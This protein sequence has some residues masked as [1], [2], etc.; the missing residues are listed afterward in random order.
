MKKNILT[1]C[2]FFFGILFVSGQ[3][4]YKLFIA[5]KSDRPNTE[6]THYYILQL[7]NE[8]SSPATFSLNNK[9]FSC[10][11]RDHKQHTDFTFEFYNLNKIQLLGNI[12]AKKNSSVKFYLKKIAP[13]NA[14]KSSWNCS[15]IEATN[16]ENK[17]VI[18]I[19]MNSLVQDSSRVN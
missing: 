10:E 1:I 9:K 15:L 3:E 11:N 2:I 14:I 7:V 13:D 17:K 6:K 12:I 19:L 5:E 18:S 16:M 8:T 4:Q